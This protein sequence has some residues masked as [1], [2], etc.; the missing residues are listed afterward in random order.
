MLDKMRILAARVR[1][2]FSRRRE[3][4][5]FDAEL[6]SHF[7]ML[8][9]EYI[10]RGMNPNEARY[11]ARRRLGGPMQIAETNRE[12]RGLPFLETFLQDL[13]FG[14]RMLRKSPGFTA[15]AV[16]TLALGI[17]ANTA[18]FSVINT[19]LLRPL[20]YKDAAQLV[21]IRASNPQEGFVGRAAAADILEIKGQARSFAQ[22]ALY[23]PWGLAMRNQGKAELIPVTSIEPDLFDVLGVAPAIGRPFTADEA[24]P[25]RGHV[26][27]LSHALW[28]QRFGSDPH[29]VGKSVILG[30]DSY[31]VVGVMPAG[32]SFPIGA[33]PGVWAPLTIGEH[34][35][36]SHGWRDKAVLARL[37]PGVSRAQA[38]AELDVL[39]GRLAQTYAKEDTG[40]GFVLMP[41]YDRLFGPIR[42]TL[43]VLFG[44]VGFVLLIACTNV[45]NLLLARNTTRQREM[46]I[47][48]AIGAG[49]ARI[50]L[51]LLTESLVLA[52]LGGSLGLLLAYGSVQA[53]RA[54]APGNV[55]RLD[56]IGVDLWVL[57]F[58]LALSAAAGI[59][60]G[61]A[62][63][64]AA[65]KPDLNDALKEGGASWKSLAG[66][67][68]SHRPHHSLAVIEIALALVLLCGSGLLIK[69][70][71]RLTGENLGF[72]PHNVLVLDLAVSS[73]SYPSAES[74]IQYFHQVLDRVGAIGGVEHAAL[75]NSGFGSNVT[76]EFSVEGQPPA[77]ENGPEAEFHIV[78]AD[79]L[80]TLRIPLLAG[81]FF[82]AADNRNGSKVV[83]ISESLAKQYLKGKNPIGKNLRFDW[84]GTG[85]WR[86]IVGVIGDARDFQL[87]EPPRPAIYVP[88]TQ[89]AQGSLTLL[90]RVRALTPDLMAAVRGQA[91]SVDKDVPVFAVETFEGTISKTVA[92]PRF[93]TL[94]LGS[95][96]GLALLLAT[97]G[98]YGLM[99]YVLTQRTR[100]IGIRMALGAS[101]GKVLRMMLRQGLGLA[102]AGVALGLAAAIGLTRLLASLLYGVKATDPPT[103]ATVTVILLFAALAASYVPARRATKVDPM[104][105][106]RYE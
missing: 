5:D 28:Q 8:A 27:I 92:E 34:E 55:P 104:V 68:G 101:P 7:E 89:L 35:L 45:A 16:L 22:I 106:L 74:Q 85:P 37:K 24:T 14:L 87:N 15:V 90:V 36:K 41:M 6:T 84:G 80:A 97:V 40:W 38:Q 75:T 94:I 88:A 48:L 77:A 82:S 70:F 39:A 18:I 32:F 73:R 79:Y 42:P 4:E 54:L 100:E 59:V 95:F 83:V 23:Q 61:L 50:V 19:V 33:P 57:G 52:G 11:A 102:L 56:S 44:A 29:V 21:D 31:M 25:G 47:R 98:T 53:I 13:R 96:A 49:R 2:L 46:A 81:R 63:A 12:L 86:E 62:P 72:D 58:T 91:Q 1:G 64:L 26:V 103:F 105:A 43:L 71:A 17:G 30:D 10:R 93:R 51:Q 76:D 65:S 67:W 66:F 78:S 69:S 9:E 20:P 60:F 3:D 99:S